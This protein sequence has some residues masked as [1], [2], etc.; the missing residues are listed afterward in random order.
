MVLS[1]MKQTAEDFLGT[2][3]TDAVITVPAYFND[4]QRQA[5]KDAGAIAGLNVLRIINEPTAAAI[6]YG[7]DKKAQG[8]RNVLIYDLGG[9]TFDVSILSLDD[10]IFEVKSTSGNSHLGGED[11]DNRMVDYCVFEFRNKHDIDLTND[12]RALRRLQTACELAKR[13]LSAS[14]Y[15]TIE[16]DSLSNGINFYTKIS[17]AKFDEMCIDL[18]RSTLQPMQSALDDAKLDKND[19]AE[20]ILVGGSTRIPRVQKLVQ[21]YFNGKQLNTSIHPDEA[22]AYGAAIQ[23]AI[24]NGEDFDALQDLILL[25]VTPLTLGIS[26]KGDIMSPIIPRNSTIPCKETKRY[27]TSENN[28]TVISIRIFEGER[29]MVKNNHLLGNFLL[30]NIPPLPAG[31]AEIDVTF[32]LDVNGILNITA[33]GLDNGSTNQITIDKHNNHR[34]SPDEIDRMIQEA[35]QMREQDANDRRLAEAKNALEA[36]V[37][38]LESTIDQQ[39]VRLRISLQDRAL[40][41]NQ[42]YQIREWIRENSTAIVG[43]DDFEHKKTELKRVCDPIISRQFT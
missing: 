34:L 28:Q 5:T 23:A 35:E 30:K 19:I 27:V 20:V 33:V 40:I 32:T 39:N 16:V 26:V 36:Y 2:K 18:F 4:A 6:A 24:L 7:L 29:E 22:V 9:G 43:I 21:D 41:E 42:V 38:Q 31:F 1:K 3:V 13:S 11:F 14:T 17:R 25:D 37:N 10:G 12:K 8:E 15:A